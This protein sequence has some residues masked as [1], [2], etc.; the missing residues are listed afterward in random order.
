[1]AVDINTRQR[2]VTRKTKKLNR[3]NL[4]RTDVILARGATFY[5]PINNKN[6][7]DLAKFVNKNEHLV[8]V[9]VYSY[10]GIN[11]IDQTCDRRW[12]R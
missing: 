3:I 9:H 4:E 2:R 1:M 12:R 8:H 11:L 7:I 10:S 5:F 6:V